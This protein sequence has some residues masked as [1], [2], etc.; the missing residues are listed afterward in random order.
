MK[1]YNRLRCIKCK[2]IM[3][4]DIKSLDTTNKYTKCPYCEEIYWNPEYK[5]NQR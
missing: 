1:G 5:G 4:E 3:L 2:R